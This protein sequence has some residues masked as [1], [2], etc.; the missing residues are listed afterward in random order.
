ADS[1]ADYCRR[2]DPVARARALRDSEP[3]FDRSA[4]QAMADLGWLGVIVP[5]QFGG[6]G[7][8]IG[9][10]AIVA[11]GAA[12][13]V[14]PEPLTAAMIATRA[15]VESTNDALKAELLPAIVAGEVIPALAWQE[16]FGDIDP[17]AVDV[18]ATVAGDKVLLSGRKRFVIGGCGADGFVVSARDGDGPALYWVP[19]SG[20]KITPVTQRLADG[21][22]VLDL[23]FDASPVPSTNRLA[24]GESATRALA[25]ALDH[26]NL[27]LGA[28]LLGL[29]HRALEITLDYLRTRTQFGRP[30]GAFQALQ[31]RAVDL[32][33][34]LRVGDAAFAH[35]L[36]IVETNDDPD[37]RGAAASRVK[38]R[39]AETARRITREA[40]QMHGAIGF[41]DDCDVGLYVKRALVLSAWLGNATLHRRRYAA[42]MPLEADPA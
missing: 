38:A 14:A 12:A 30:I 9:D 27:A 35:A 33:I 25:V 7:L 17:A 26:G 24:S 15:L 40:I 21:R 41:T 29:A 34:H 16:T 18:S 2:S 10:H 3:G 36:R 5:E 20:P 19:A 11:R 23:V 8:S 37:L 6:L 22:P 39:A 13:A 1:V 31:H 42:L 32:Y 4:W 28:E